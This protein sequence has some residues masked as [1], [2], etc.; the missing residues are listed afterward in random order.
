M[1]ELF[2]RNTTLRVGLSETSLRG[3]PDVDFLCNK[4]HKNTASLGDLYKLYVFTKSLQSIE[5]LL[6]EH[7]DQL[8]FGLANGSSGSSNTAVV[9]K[10]L[11][12]KYI[13]PLSTMNRKFVNYQSLIE[14]VIDFNALPEFIVDAKHD[15]ELLE[16]KTN[17]DELHSKMEHVISQSNR[18]WWN[19]NIQNSSN[20]SDIRIEKSL[21]HGY[22]MRTTKGKW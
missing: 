8:A 10:D 15:E 9:L 2:H 20:S 4:L 18:T 1:V 14:H 7:S 16:I 19:S 13:I 17:M 11:S 12:D 22:I 3:I 6:Q 5:N 21:M